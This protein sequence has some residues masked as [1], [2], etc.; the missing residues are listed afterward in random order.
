[1][2]HPISHV[3]EPIL[4]QQGVALFATVMVIILMCLLG[5]TAITLTA[6]EVKV[7]TLSK[8]T[9]AATTAAESCLTT[10]VRVIQTSLE[11]LAVPDSSLDS[12]TPPGPVPAARSTDLFSELIGQDDQSTDSTQTLPDLVQTVS[13]FTVTGDIDRLYTQE[14]SGGSAQFGGGYNGKQQRD[15]YYRITCRASWMATGTIATVDEI[16]VCG[17]DGGATCRKT[18]L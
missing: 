10:G 17:M 1:M 2:T 11:Q 8:T 15:L 16:Y 6:M 12:A 14:K 9:D 13:G 7:A 4:N 18:A 5:V 3:K